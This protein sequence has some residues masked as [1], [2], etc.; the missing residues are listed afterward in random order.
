MKND[1]ECENCLKENINILQRE[2][3]HHQFLNDSQLSIAIIKEVAVSRHKS[4]YT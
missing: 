2:L 1:V 4:L 3:N